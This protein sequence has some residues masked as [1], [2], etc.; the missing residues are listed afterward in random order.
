MKK[1]TSIIRTKQPF[2]PAVGHFYTINFSD[3]SQVE[4]SDDELIGKYAWDETKPVGQQ[5]DFKLGER[6]GR[7]D[8]AALVGMDWIEDEE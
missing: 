2:H 1:I 7:A 3:G 8:W 4:A 6:L 5:L